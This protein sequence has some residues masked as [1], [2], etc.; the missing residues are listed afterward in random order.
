MSYQF[1]LRSLT[2]LAAAALV[3]GSP[4]AADA[5]FQRPEKPVEVQ[6]VSP[7]QRLVI[8]T[9]PA[10]ETHYTAL[11][12]F[13]PDGSTLYVSSPRIWKIPSQ[14]VPGPDERKARG[15][16]PAD[17]TLSVQKEVEEGELIGGRN[18]Q[19]EAAGPAIRVVMGGTTSEISGRPEQWSNAVAAYSVAD[20]RQTQKYQPVDPQRSE[21]WERFTCGE[22]S[23][24]GKYL[25]FAVDSYGDVCIYET[26]SG[27]LILRDER[28]R[29]LT[30]SGDE[31][32]FAFLR[33]SEQLLTLKNGSVRIHDVRTGRKL[34]E[35]DM[36]TPLGMSVNRIHT[37][38]DADRFSIQSSIWNAQTAELINDAV[39]KSN[40]RSQSIV[41]ISAD[42][43]LLLGEDGYTVFCVTQGAYRELL[44]RKR[45][46]EERQ[47]EMGSVTAAALSD[48]A[49]LFA[50]SLG[51][52]LVIYQLLNEKGEIEP[53]QLEW[54]PGHLQTIDGLAF[55]R[56]AK[57]LASTSADGST[58]IW[59]LADLRPSADSHAPPAG[60]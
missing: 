22:L 17:I 38:R 5:Q 42:G 51:K 13:S 12:E 3:S 15:G 47:E 26:E 45:L 54:L 33:N 37:A 28:K 18:K 58:R 23:F 14:P 30:F 46:A 57:L 41:A 7:R 10:D 24:D 40:S 60:E 52:Q 43:T 19:R 49:K 31:H 50:C 9:R 8:M 32:C 35:E 2:L 39:G 27:S 53:V 55:S 11:L 44:S 34:D 36:A 48:D 21:Q 56:D 59:D 25:A 1:P 20:G 6:P 16:S 4:R 29:L